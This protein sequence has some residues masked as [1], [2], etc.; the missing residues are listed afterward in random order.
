MPRA[1][2]A[3]PTHRVLAAAVDDPEVIVRYREKVLEVDGTGCLW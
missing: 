2:L 3:V 1:G